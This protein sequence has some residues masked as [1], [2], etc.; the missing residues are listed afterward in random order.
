[1]SEENKILEDIN[2]EK[3]LNYY[4]S[5]PSNEAEF[6]KRA[7]ELGFTSAPLRLGK[8]TKTYMKFLSKKYK[9]ETTYKNAPIVKGKITKPFQ[10]YMD[11]GGLYVKDFKNF[12]ENNTSFTANIENKKELT[13]ILETMLGVNKNIIM[14]YTL[15]DGR[16]KVYTLNQQS[17]KDILLGA[18]LQ[19]QLY[20]EK[21]SDA[22]FATFLQMDG[23]KSVRFDNVNIKKKSG[24]FFKFTH[25]IKGLDLTDLQ[26]FNN[27]GQIQP[28]MPCCFIQSLICANVD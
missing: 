9:D 15:E 18:V 11:E 14:E 27:V 2:M 6:K 25:K 4:L 20:D 28:N 26:I 24:A 16:K 13:K 17:A 1:M 19:K 23:I 8:P 10:K 3:K 22:E 5:N 7:K 12:L 21:Q